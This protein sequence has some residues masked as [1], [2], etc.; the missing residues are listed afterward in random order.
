MSLQN[1]KRK[2]K[3][4]TEKLF[5]GV[6]S[7]VPSNRMLQNNLSLFEWAK[8]NKTHPVFW[9]RNI[10]GNDC[11]TKEEVDFLNKKA[12][13]IVSLYVDDDHN[14]KG[15]EEQGQLAAEKAAKY[16][17][18]L[19]IPK[20]TVVFLEIEDTETAT[21]E[22]LKGYAAG[23]MN[24][25]YTPGLKANTDSL[26]RFDCE[27]SRGL[28]MYRDV[29]ESCL[30]WATAPN[31]KE[32]NKITTTHLIHPDCW[33]PFAPSGIS[34]RDIAMWQYGKECHEI[35]DDED[36]KVVFNIDLV[37]NENVVIDKMF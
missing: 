29:F 10:S 28:Q 30:I 25:G 36:N 15:T 19:G 16:A 34:R 4:M 12:C 18:D 9:V 24:L 5:W 22:Y 20:E 6:D 11:L 13:R 3:K 37:M 1:Q 33:K 21:T 27:Y 2:D 17:S 32:Y 23:I 31:V 8:R 14:V 35:Y 7:K 26:Y